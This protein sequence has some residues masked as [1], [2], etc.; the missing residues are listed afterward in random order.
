[1]TQTGLVLLVM[2]QTVLVGLMGLVLL[3]ALV[4]LVGLVL[5]LVLVVLVHL[6]VLVGLVGLVHLLVLVDLVSQA[7]LVALL[8]TGCAGSGL[9]PPAVASS[10]AVGTW[11]AWSN[12]LV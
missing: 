7:V 12:G 3:L 2:T 11:I 10:C 9:R 1:M 5:L 8:H 6:L 4:G